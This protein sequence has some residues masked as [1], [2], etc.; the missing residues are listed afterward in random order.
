MT[1]HPIT[2][3]PSQL[4]SALAGRLEQV[5]FFVTLSDP[6]Q[7]YA[8]HDDDGW[9]CSADEYG[10]WHRDRCPWGVVGD[11]LTCDV[12]LKT[13][14][15]CNGDRGWI[16]ADGTS[17]DCGDCEGE[18]EVGGFDIT[19]EIVGIRVERLGDMSEADAY[20]CGAEIPSHMRFSSGG[21]PELRNEA[22]CVY[23][24]DWDAQHG[25][26]YPWASNPFAWVLDVRKMGE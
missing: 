8:V 25:Q 1:T 20:R 23:T 5:R 7:T 26:R 21:N 19:F 17:M 9:P 4:R 3:T 24:S 6:S 15:R 10:D 12:P 16:F 14:F 18:G 13:C 2:L 11:R 22:R